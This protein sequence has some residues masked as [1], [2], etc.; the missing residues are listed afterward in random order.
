M[1]ARSEKLAE[2][3]SAEFLEDL[4]AADIV[5]AVGEDGD[6][7]Y[8]VFLLEPPEK[9]FSEVRRV[10]VLIYQDTEELEALLAAVVVA[11]GYHQYKASGGY[12]YDC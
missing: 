8:P 4:K 6:W 1:E 5:L 2:L 12:V 7:G 3:R 11:K 9:L 10:T